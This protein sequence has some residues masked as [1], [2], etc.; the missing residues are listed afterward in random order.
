MSAYLRVDDVDK[1]RAELVSSG[2]QVRD[3]PRDTD[4]TVRELMH[5][6][7]DRN[8]QIFVSPRAQPNQALERPCELAR[9][10]TA[11]DRSQSVRA[12][13]FASA[14]KR[15]DAD[16]VAVL[17]GDVPALTTALINSYR[18]L[19]LYEDT[20]SVMSRIFFVK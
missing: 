1:I 5:V 19:H 18:P 12:F 3:A 8:V 14:L 16:Q 10:S 9:S 20:P 7:P 4:S 15:G 17:L 6:D 11:T 2:R 13:E